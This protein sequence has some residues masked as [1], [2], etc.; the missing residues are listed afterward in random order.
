MFEKHLLMEKKKQDWYQVQVVTTFPRH[1]SKGD[2]CG[3]FL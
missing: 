3:N 1:L 2:F